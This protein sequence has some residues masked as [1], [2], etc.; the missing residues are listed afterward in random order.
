MAVGQRT[1]LGESS[2]QTALPVREPAS[3]PPGKE[4]QAEERGRAKALR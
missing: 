4:F 1:L 2:T 3:H